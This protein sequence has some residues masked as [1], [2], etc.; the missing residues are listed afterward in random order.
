[1][2]YFKLNIQHVNPS[3]AQ[4]SHTWLNCADIPFFK[5][6]AT[7][8]PIMQM[9][10]ILQIIQVVLSII[11]IA[12]ILMQSKTSGLSG[13]F[14][15][16]DSSGSFQTRRGLEKTIFHATIVIATLFVVVSFIIFAI[17]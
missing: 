9:Q 8:V 17:S 16:D 3:P 11:L 15:G 12:G 2:V 14:G 4:F 1:M 6:C 13:A 5:K 10:T 7:I